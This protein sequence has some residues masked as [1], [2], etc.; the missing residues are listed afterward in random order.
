MSTNR[1]IENDEAVVDIRWVRDGR[2]IRSFGG[3]GD[4]RPEI[5][6]YRIDARSNDASGTNLHG[7]IA[8]SALRALIEAGAGILGD[9][10]PVIETPPEPETELHLEEP[11]P[12]H[13]LMQRTARKIW[14]QKRLRD[15]G[16]E[17]KT[18]DDP[19]PG[20]LLV[21]EDLHA[22]VARYEGDI[23]H[24]V[25]QDKEDAEANNAD[26]EMDRWPM[27]QGVVA[28]ITEGMIEAS[29]AI[30]KLLDGRAADANKRLGGDE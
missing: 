29:E 22:S 8:G 6:V 2:T 19:T 23:F 15:Y 17:W 24:W 20:L 7:E 3:G 25:L 28:G 13:T 14:L 21:F 26:P 4:K 27:Q 5:P 16:A 30:V 11:T 10:K 9:P 1:R 18:A 12:E